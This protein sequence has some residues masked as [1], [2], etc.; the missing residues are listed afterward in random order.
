MHHLELGSLEWSTFKFEVTLDIKLSLFVP[1]GADE[2]NK[3]LHVGLFVSI[4]PDVLTATR[5]NVSWNMH[6]GVV[7]LS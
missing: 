5:M 7:F 3:S 1:D 4:H 6:L 2:E